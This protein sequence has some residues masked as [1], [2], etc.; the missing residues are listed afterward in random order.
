[1][2]NAVDG[3]ANRNIEHNIQTVYVQKNKEK[4]RYT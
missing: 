2:A 3:L 4:D 1:M